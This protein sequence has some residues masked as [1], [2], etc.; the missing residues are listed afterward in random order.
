[1]ENVIKINGIVYVK[2][3]A[4]VSKVEVGSDNEP[5]IFDYYLD[6]ENNNE[7]CYPE[8]LTH[9]TEKNDW[10]YIQCFDVANPKKLEII[11]MSLDI[12]PEKRRK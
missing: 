3:T 8:M 4:L 7:H 11:E 12:R 1:M 10:D 2:A 5:H 9:Y 6:R